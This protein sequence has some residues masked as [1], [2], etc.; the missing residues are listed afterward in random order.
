MYSY[1]YSTVKSVRSDYHLIYEMIVPVLY[2][3]FHAPG[4]SIVDGG[5]NTGLHSLPMSRMIARECSENRSNGRLFSLE[6]IPDIAEKLRNNILLTGTQNIT[7]IINKAFSNTIGYIDF[8]VNDDNPGLSGIASLVSDFSNTTKI[9]VPLTTID[10]EIDTSVDFIKLDLEGAEFQCMQG[11][12]I[13]IKNHRPLI[14]FEN[15]LKW[16]ATK[17]NY[18]VQ[19]F[20][21]FFDDLDYDIFTIH[22]E[23]VSMENYDSNDLGFEF[24]AAP[25]NIT[26]K[27]MDNIERFWHKILRHSELK[28]WTET[29]HFCSNIN[30]IM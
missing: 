19:D 14:V 24:I 13:L 3:S 28:D 2:Q 6:A 26:F 27:V 15:G 22:N 9:T 16:S 1:S 29:V 10:S 23:T 5:A 7:T 21:G 8:I 4:K 25:K 20:F 30:K 18:S 17:G 12:I 11:G